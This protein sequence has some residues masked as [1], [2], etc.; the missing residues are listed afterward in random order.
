MTTNKD[1]VVIKV[2]EHSHAGDARQQ[3]IRTIANELRTDAMTTTNTTREIVD[4][5]C[6]KATDR[7]IRMALPHRNVM[8]QSVRR[9]RRKRDA[10]AVTPRTVAELDISGAFAVTK[11]NE[12]FVMFDS[13]ALDPNE[14]RR[15]I[16][17]STDSSVD[18]L[19][20]IN[21]RHSFFRFD[22]VTHLFQ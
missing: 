13:G 12:N 17:F 4:T 14:N 10:P 8:S 9:Y 3:N 18:Y 2:K 1:D 19:R 22:K 16:I 21:R 20:F 11:T 7:A 5:A 15:L 6:A